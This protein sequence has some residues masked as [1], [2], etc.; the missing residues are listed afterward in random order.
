MLKEKG[1]ETEEDVE[2][3]DRRESFEKGP[4]VE[5]EYVF[6]KAVGADNLDA[7]TLRQGC[8]CK[9]DDHP[10]HPACQFNIPSK[11]II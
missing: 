11:N 2:E 4:S 9:R 3:A 5:A 7:V 1:K 6:M 8:R 10:V